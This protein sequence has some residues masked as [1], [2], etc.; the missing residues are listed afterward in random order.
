MKNNILPPVK[1]GDTWTFTFSW[2]NQ[3]T[4]IDLTGCS[5]RMQIRDKRTG[6]MFAESSTVDNSITIDG[7]AGGV[8]VEFS[9]DKTS[10]IDPGT[11]YSDLEI[12]FPVS[13]RVQSSGTVIIIV[14]GDITR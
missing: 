13:G 5:A 8:S 9:S 6:E 14:Q 10:F 2:K 7:L 4:P 12:T 3:N 11:Y 1:R